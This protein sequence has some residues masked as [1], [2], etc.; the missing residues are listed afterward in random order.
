MG[1]IVRIGLLVRHVSSVVKQLVPKVMEYYSMAAPVYAGW[2]IDTD[3]YY[4]TTTKY[5]IDLTANLLL[6]TEKYLY[7]FSSSSYSDASQL[8]IAMSSLESNI[9]ILKQGGKASGIVLKPFPSNLL[10]LWNNVDNM[11][12]IYK[13]YV[14][15]KLLTLPF[16]ARTATTTIDQSQEIKEVESVAS[17]LIKSSDNLVT[18]LGQQTYNNTQNLMLLQVLFAILIIGILVLILYV[19]TRMLRPIVDLT[20]AIS[21][22][23]K[24]NLDVSVKQK[25]CDEL[26]SLS[27]S[28]N[29]MVNVII[30]IS[31]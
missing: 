6:Q 7:G 4:E 17:N 9:M 1:I 2:S 19:V 26:S 3:I 15:N 18:V 21:K 30:K 5:S 23:K 22:V 24:G 14:T 12:N 31:K 16:E 13:T 29:S 20:Q 10:P 25:G 27:Q 8:K 11:W 28:F